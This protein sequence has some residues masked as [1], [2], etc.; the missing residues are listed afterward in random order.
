MY[1]SRR[2]ERPRRVKSFDSGNSGLD[3]NQINNEFNKS[4]YIKIEDNKEYN[5]NVC[6]RG[7]ASVIFSLKNEIGGLVKALKL[8]QEKHV[9]LIHIESRKS[10]RRN[11]EFEIFVDCDSNREQLNEIFHLLKPHV[12]VISMSPPENFSV[13]E[14]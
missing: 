3:E 11:S 13:E 12:S 10:K 4:T 1:S 2:A 9:N 5:D 8:F 7:K 6:E 14:D